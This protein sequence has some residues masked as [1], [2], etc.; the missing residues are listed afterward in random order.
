MHGILPTAGTQAMLATCNIAAAAAAT[1]ESL[2]HIECESTAM[3]ND[4][5]SY[6]LETAKIASEMPV[7]QI[8]AVIDTLFGAWQRRA[9]I[10][11]VGNGGSASTASHWAV[12]LLKIGAEED[13]PPV[14][15]ICLADSV[16][17]I[18]AITN[19]FAADDVFEVQLRALGSPGDILIAISVH[20]SEGFGSKH[21]WSQNLVQAL[22][23]GRELGLTT[24]GVTGFD[25]GRFKELCDICVTVPARTISHVEDFHVCINHLVASELLQRI[26]RSTLRA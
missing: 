3:N 1:A 10:F 11:T 13:S 25:G 5:A 14:R 24:I 17:M 19:D 4:P 16:A 21:A 26:R 6:F 15:A 9:R 18:T 8:G 12:D 2:L 23:A 22:V 7:A 20:G